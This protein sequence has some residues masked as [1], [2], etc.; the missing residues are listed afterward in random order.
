[1]GGVW[2]C[3]LLQQSRRPRARA[4]AGSV[5]Q[6]SDWPMADT[7]HPTS[8]CRRRSAGRGRRHQLQRHRLVRRD[9]DDRHDVVCQ[10]LVWAACSRSSNSDRRRTTRR[11]RRWPRRP[12]TLPPAPNLLSR[13]SRATCRRSARARTAALTTYDWVD[14]DDGHGAHPD[15]SRERTRDRARAPARH[16]G[17][18]RPRQRSRHDGHGSDEGHD[19]N[20][21]SRIGRAR[22]SA[23]AVVCFVRFVSFVAL[24][25]AAR[26]RRSR[27]AHCPCRRPARLRPS[28]FRC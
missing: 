27:R 18:D 23:D 6:G 24:F 5:L 2:L 28:R 9:P 12:G 19:S 10:M 16:G 1:M 17:R 26:V 25:V 14:K 11:G 15:R 13:T 21:Q 8:R 3:A 4:G 22:S 7:K 20:R